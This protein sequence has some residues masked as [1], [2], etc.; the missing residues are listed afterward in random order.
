MIPCLNQALQIVHG[1]AAK[2]SCLAR[3]IGVAALNF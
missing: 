2:D 1:D 3:N